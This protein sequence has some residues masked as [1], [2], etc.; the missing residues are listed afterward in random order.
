MFLRENVSRSRGR[1]VG[2]KLFC[3]HVSLNSSYYLANRVKDEK[4][5]QEPCLDPVGCVSHFTACIKSEM[6]AWTSRGKNH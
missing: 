4:Q 2:E 1:S 5:T 6:C 3:K